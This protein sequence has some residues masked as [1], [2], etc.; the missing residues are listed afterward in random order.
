[1]S[2]YV[3]F[4]VTRE[5]SAAGAVVRVAGEVDLHSAGVLAEAMGAHGG[6]PFD[7]DLADTTLMDSSALNVLITAARA[8]AVFTVCNPNASVRRLFE[9]TGL[10]SYLSPT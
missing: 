1:M 5:V 9:L 4:S 8:G 2:G 6:H 10:A 7:L 3:P